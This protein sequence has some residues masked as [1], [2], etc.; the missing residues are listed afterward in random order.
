[1]TES[2]TSELQQLVQAG[3][4][5]V[6]AGDTS[7]ARAS[8]RRATELD[9]SSAEAWVGLSSAVPILAE[10]REYLRRALDLE[11][12]SADIAASLR[13]VE[14][15]LAQGMQLEPSRRREE[16][17]V[18]GDASPLLSAPE[19][20][21]TAVEYCYR[22]PDRE[23]GL[24]CIQCGRPICGECATMT[25]VG[26]LCPDDR[27]ARRP[28]NYKVSAR[29]VLVGGVVALF[30]SALVAIP[31]W[32]FSGRLGFFGLI[33]IFMAG[34]AIAEFVVRVVDRATKL[35]RGRPMQITV[36]AAMVLGTLPFVLLGLNLLLL[37]YMVL[38]VS[39]A[40]A[41]LR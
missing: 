37:L 41:R 10:K 35:K 30:A 29:D 39:T 24:H 23:T 25:S 38:A 34:P 20:A 12:H 31:L 40:V 27:R 5:A 15:L 14:Q 6:M 33:I 19:Q 2:T 8:F 16:R 32:L 28:S 9:S 13:Y 36:G 22:H 17:N 21:A 7:A 3:R 4:A 11:P 18:S 26:Q 1:M